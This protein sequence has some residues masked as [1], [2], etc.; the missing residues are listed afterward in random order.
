MSC[1]RRRNNELL[2]LEM[3]GRFRS[4]ARGVVALEFLFL[5]PFIIAMLYASASY[6]ITFFAKYQ[7]QGAVDRAVA[8]ALYVDR[9]S[10]EANE[11][12]STCAGSG[13]FSAEVCDRALNTLTAIKGTL[14]AWRA[15]LAQESCDLPESA[16]ITF[17]R[18]TLVYENF[19]ENPIVPTISFGMLGEF[20]PLPKSLEVHARA[21]F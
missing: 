3:S 14:P 2:V 10:Y 18:C 9:S 7:M 12:G 20:P 19:K 17:I 1:R 6:G 5:F 21:A 11:S 15:K 16:G 4:K 8:A 13:G